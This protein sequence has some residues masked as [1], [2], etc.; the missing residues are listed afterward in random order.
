MDVEGWHKIWTVTEL[1]QLVWKDGMKHCD[2]TVSI[3]IEGWHATWTVI[4]L[5][6]LVWK[7]GMKHGL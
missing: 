6:Q 3:S 7:D 5:F 2:W 4:E 1:F